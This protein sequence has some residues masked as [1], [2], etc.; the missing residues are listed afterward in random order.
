MHSAVQTLEA[1][2]W[3]PSSCDEFAWTFLRAEVHKLG[4]LRNSAL[5]ATP[6]FSDAAENARRKELLAGIRACLLKRIPASTNWHRLQFLHRDH[7]PHLYVIG[8]CGWDSS[9]DQNQ[10]ERVAVRFQ[11][12]LQ[13]SATRWPPLILWGHTRG[14]D[15][16]ILEGNNRL[17]AYAGAADTTP[18]SAEVL[19]GLS[20]EPCFWHLADG[21]PIPKA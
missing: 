11:I 6:N 1:Q 20:A 9:Q 7:F 16:T 12:K 21:L 3:T 17:V 19:V 4:A 5:L 10:L 2:L 8:R 15:F 13:T 18:I 14:G